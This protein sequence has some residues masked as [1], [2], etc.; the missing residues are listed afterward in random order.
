M[1]VDKKIEEWEHM[2]SYGRD[3]TLEMREAF[4]DAIKELKACRRT[5]KPPWWPENPYPIEIFPMP[6]EDY[7]KIIPDPNTRT[8]VSG[9]LGREFWEIASKS[10]YDALKSEGIL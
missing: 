9:M 3:I 10:I 4:E 6:R 1:N 5:D 8:A 7:S 2:L